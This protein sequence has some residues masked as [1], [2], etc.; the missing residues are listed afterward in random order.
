[1]KAL[2][3]GA[4]GK[5]PAGTRVTAVKPK[6]PPPL[7]MSQFPKPVTL[8]IGKKPVDGKRVYDALLPIAR[9][10]RDDAEL[11]DFG[12]LGTGLDATGKSASWNVKFYSRSAQKMNLMSV[13]A[14]VL[15]AMPVQSNEMRIVAVTGSTTLDT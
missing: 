3:T 15:T 1:M 2:I 8:A 5:E 13:T 9:K 12:T 14:G 11:V 4:A 7:D 6:A 10:W